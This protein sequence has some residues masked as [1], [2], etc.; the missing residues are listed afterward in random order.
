MDRF[1]DIVKSIIFG[2][3]SFAGKL[4]DIV[5]I[6]TIILSVLFV[7]LDSIE[8][9]HIVYGDF[10]YIAEWI[11]TILFSIEYLL[12]IYIIRL[13]SSYI[14]SFFGIIDFLALIPTYLSLI[15]PGVGVFS[16]IRVLRV[17][18]VF[19]VLK[20]VQFMGEAEMLMKAMK[21]SKRKIFVYLFFLLNLVII[22]GSIMY[23]VEGENAGFDSIP[24]SIYWAIVTLTTV[25]YG[26]ISPV[27]SLG[28][29]IAA[30]IMIM[31]YSIIAV[32][33]GIVT[34]AMHYTKDVSK[35][36]CVVCDDDKQSVDAKFCNH[37][38]AKMRN[39]Q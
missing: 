35:N 33:T 18:R 10:F 25:G 6:N 15:L 2:T 22:L 32:P 16:V 14:F 5:L 4:F 3:D 38:G 8:R 23:L 37:C 39:N 24:R 19:R 28:Q 9:Y 36:T 34:S 17:L 11:F 27:S 20:L 1:K 31:G 26:D 21:A 12:R 13:P 30:I 29:A 7:M